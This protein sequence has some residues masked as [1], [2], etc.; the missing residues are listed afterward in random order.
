[1]WQALLF[2]VI[3]LPFAIGTAWYSIAK[4]K[5][6][7]RGTQHITRAGHPLQFWFWIGFI[8]LWC[9]FALWLT[10]PAITA[11]LQTT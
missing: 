8:G 6:V 5:L 10:A 2:D 9:V 3:A 1:M 7:Y 11:G 4:G